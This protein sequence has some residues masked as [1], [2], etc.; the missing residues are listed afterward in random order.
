MLY[1]INKIK[2]STSTNSQSSSVLLIYTGGTLGMVRDPE[3]NVLVPND[4]AEILAN[5]PE[6]DRLDFEISQISLEK[7]FDSANIQPKIWIELA[8]LIK[9]YYNDFDGFVIIHGTDT[10]AYTASALSFLLENLS[11]PVIFTGAQLPIGVPRTDARENLITSMEIAATKI[12]GLPVVPE[13]TIYFNSSLLRGNRSK[14]VES[15]Q[16]DAFRAENYPELAT[17]GVTIEFNHSLIKPYYPDLPLEVHE[18][19]D[20]RVMILKLFPGI[21]QKMVHNLLNIPELKG[22]VMET[23]GAGNAPTEDWFLN[24]LRQAIARNIIIINISQCFGGRVMQGAYDTRKHLQEMGIVSGSDIT[25]EAAIT[26]LMYLLGKENRCR[27]IKYLLEQ[28]L[29]GELSLD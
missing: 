9:T 3:T 11:K 7:K 29:V 15:E 22:V 24:E 10:M 2:S 26:K 5:I 18:N 25:T 17:A 14:K 21:S 12:N 20:E 8:K 4:F 13:V 23:Y 1:T 6:I 19:L 27:K 16:F 28:P